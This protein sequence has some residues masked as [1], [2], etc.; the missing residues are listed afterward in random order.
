MAEARTPPGAYRSGPLV[1][2]NA[3]L[4]TDL[5][6]L[7][8]AASYLREGRPTRPSRWHTRW[9]GVESGSP[10]FAWTAATWWS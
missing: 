5:Y 8:M 3:A 6:E 4:L 2:E 9:R 1:L 10:A 7:T